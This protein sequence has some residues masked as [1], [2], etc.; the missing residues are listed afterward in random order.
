ME[1]TVKKTDLVKELSLGQGV[2]ERKTTI[3]VLS[4]VL[5]EADGEELT[6]TVTDLEL[7]IRTSCP[8]VTARGG[9][10]TIPARRFLDYVRLLPDAELAVKTLENDSVSLVWCRAKTRIAGMSRENFPSCRRCRPR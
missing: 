10:T 7:G 1:L 5:V 3:P 4:N 9:S 6:L 2:I 8:A